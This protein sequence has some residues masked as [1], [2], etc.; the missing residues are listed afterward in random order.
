MTKNIGKNI[1]ENISGK[2]S[3][4]LYDHDKQSSADS[5]KTASKKVIQ[6]TAGWTG[7]LIGNTI[8]N[9]ISKVFIVSTQNIS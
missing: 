6:K 2:R 4:N 3:Q 8:T 1:I 7:E 9:S 5:L